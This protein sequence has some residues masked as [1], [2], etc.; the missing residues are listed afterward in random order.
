MEATRSRS[1]LAGLLA[2]FVALALTLVP[3]AGA[4]TRKV[5]P[6]DRAF[7]AQWELADDAIM[8]ARSAWS[9]STGSGVVVAVVDTGAQLDHPDLVGNLWTNP[10]DGS[11]G[12]DFVNHDNDPTD[13]NGHG[14]NVAGIIAARGNNG[15]GVTGVAPH[16]K[17]MIVKVLGADGSGSEGDVAAGILYAVRNGARIINLSMAGA[18]DDPTLESALQVAHDAG[19]LVVAAAGNNGADLDTTPAYP[20][21]APLDNV[22]AVASTDERGRLAG[23]SA[24][25]AGSVAIAAPGEDIDSTATGGR[26]AVRSGTSQ[27]AAHVTGVL[28]LEAAAKPAATAEELRAALLDGARPAS[29]PVAAGALD[30][31]GALR[32]LAGGARRSVKRTVTTRTRTRAAARRSVVTAA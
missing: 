32:A 28:A 4:A 16:A 11:H 9:T 10:A 1:R 5:T 12:Y 21:S 14:T 15:I 19:V 26:Y 22:V 25:G 23:D 13:D 29:L 17:L 27:A 6:N 30:A 18:Q 8:G 31:A 20:A 7:S 2:T 3:A 24:Y